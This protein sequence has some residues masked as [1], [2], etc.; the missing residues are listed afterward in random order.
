MQAYGYARVSTKEQHSDRQIHSLKEAGVSEKNIFTDTMSGKN[1][2]RLRYEQLLALLKSGDR[3]I[4][5]SIDRLGRSYKEI[6]EQ[7]RIIT[8]DIQAD[9]TVL[10]MP[11]LDTSIK[12]DLLGTFI[13][14]VVLQILS[15]VA[16]NERE[17]TMLRQSE[18]II[19]AKK[20][21][22]KFGRPKLNPPFDF[23]EIKKDY[24]EKKLSSRT[25]AKRLNVS[26]FTFLRWIRG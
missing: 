5:K 21:G 16:Q 2:E 12:R 14:D 25:A 4:V 20:R 3:L 18:G 11:L 17:V 6:V 1:F 24:I 7:W 26:Q 15:F 19:Q 23:A 10:D 13:S 8:K 9:I 22:V